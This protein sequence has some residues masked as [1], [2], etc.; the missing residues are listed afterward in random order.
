MPRS[1]IRAGLIVPKVPFFAIDVFRKLN[2]STNFSIFS[3]GNK[4]KDL[5]HY[6]R[7]SCIIF[8]FFYLLCYYLIRIFFYWTDTKYSLSFNG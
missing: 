3:A 7:I 2:N 5:S 8:I 6:Q 4:Y 1:S